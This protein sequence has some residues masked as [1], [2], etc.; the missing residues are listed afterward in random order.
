MRIQA[1]VVRIIRQF[2]RDKRTLALMIIAPM[3]VLFLMD[4]V[5]NGETYEPKIAIDSNVPQQLA[6]ALQETDAHVTTMTKKKAMD[7]LDDQ[8]IDAFIEMDKATLRITLEGSDPSVSKQVLMTVQK[9]AQTLMPPMKQ[10]LTIDTVYMYGSEHMALFDNFGPVLIGFFIFFFVF[11]IAGVS[12]LRERTSGTLE[13]LLATPLKR[14]EIVIG[15]VIGFGIF[16]TIQ[17]TFISLF[18]IHVL[19]MMMEGSFGYVLL[20]TFLFAMT[21]LT[22]GTLLSAFANNE[23][24]MIQFIPLVVVPQVFFSGLFNLDTMEPWLRSIGVAMP[25]Y[26]GADAL[27]EIMIRGKG[28]EAISFDVYVLVGFSLLFMILNV[29]ALKKYRKL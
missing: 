6:D 10:T 17:A 2:F 14:W 16:T 20:V 12:F 22:L 27:R 18:A 4:L 26:Y 8:Q 1:I 21:A 25:L 28:W 9:A 29:L 5:F 15:Y 19:N 11:L 24:Q 13:R 3:F 7:K 23:L